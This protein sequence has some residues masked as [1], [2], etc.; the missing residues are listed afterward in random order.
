MFDSIRRKGGNENKIARSRGME[1]HR[2][3]G[4]GRTDCSLYLGQ[5]T[6]SIGS[7]REKLYTARRRPETGPENQSLSGRTNGLQIEYIGEN[8]NPLDSNYIVHMF[9]SRGYELTVKRAGPKMMS[10][11]NFNV[12]RPAFPQLT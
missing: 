2:K 6:F 12:E 9:N 10:F 8:D 11:I 1:C 3:G 5:A 4:P 7:T